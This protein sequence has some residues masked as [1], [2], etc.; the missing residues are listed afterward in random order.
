MDQ[1]LSDVLLHTVPLLARGCNVDGLATAT[2]SRVSCRPLLFTKMNC[3]G[4][5]W[6]PSPIP[7]VFPTVQVATD[8]KSRR[9][10]KQVDC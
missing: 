8:G 10:G 3:E 1:F 6:H 2:R 4:T 7:N 9:L 5:L